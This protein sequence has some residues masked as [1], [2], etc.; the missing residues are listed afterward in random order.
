MALSDDQQKL[1]DALKQIAPQGSYSDE[2]LYELLTAEGATENS[3]AARLWLIE[4][5]RTS[6]YFDM[7]EGSSRRN[8]GDLHENAVKSAAYFKGL[9]DGETGGPGSRRSRTRAI[10]RA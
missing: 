9:A 3:V 6:V 7:A 10:V 8:L 2:D 5:K 4:V 1:V